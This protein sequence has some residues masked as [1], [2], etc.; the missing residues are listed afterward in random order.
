MLICIPYYIL[1]SPNIKVYLCLQY[2]L[3]L[4]S[5]I[6]KRHKKK[7]T[8]CCLCGGDREIRT[9]AAL[10][11]PNSLANCPLRPAWV[12][13]QIIWRRGWDSNPRYAH[14]YAN[15]QDWCLKPTR[16]PLRI[17]LYK[18]NITLNDCQ[19]IKLIFLKFLGT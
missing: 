1:F 14:T 11:N 9:L 15:F 16:P 10:A 19:Q 8:Q 6:V 7:T 5:I 4:F 13:L 17:T 18:Y 2:I 12:C 3:P